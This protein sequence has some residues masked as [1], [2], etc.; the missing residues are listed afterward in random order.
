MSVQ[1]G[2]TYSKH[3]ALKGVKYIKILVFALLD[4]LIAAYEHFMSVEFQSDAIR[5]VHMP[6]F[7]NLACKKTLPCL[8]KHSAF[9]KRNFNVPLIFMKL[10]L[11]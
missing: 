7:C 11:F 6:L 5:F 9:N 2:G 4:T 3:S 10:N 8:L 1:G